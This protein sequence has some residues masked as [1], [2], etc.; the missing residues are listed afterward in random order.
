MRALRR[1]VVGLGVVVV[2]LALV[3]VFGGG[4]YY[5]GELL[6][7]PTYVPD[8]PDRDATFEGDQVTLAAD[9]ETCLE[10]VGLR[11]AE[12]YVQ[13][14][15]PLAACPEGETVTRPY[16]SVIG[17]PSE[18]PTQVAADLYFWPG[19]PATAGLRFEEVAVPGPFGDLP[20]W[21]LA[22]DDPTWVVAV[23]GRGASRGEALRLASILVD[24]GHPMLIPS[25]RGDGTAPAPDGGIGRFGTEEWEDVEAAVAW[26]REQG[27]GAVVLA[28]FSQGGSAVAFFLERSAH[29]AGI[30]GA[31]LDAPLL[32]LPATLEL[33]AQARD[34]PAVLIP[35]ILFG[36]G[37]V[38]RLRAGLV[39]GEVD[40]VTAAEE[41]RVP[42]LLFHGD[43]DDSVPIGPSD[44][45]AAA[46]PDSVTYVRVEDAGH[47]QSWNRDPAAYAEAVSTFLD[48][49][50]PGV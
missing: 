11:S 44:T 40:H 24:L 29:A 13:L 39:I 17:T 5:S 46:L 35:P 37:I 20:S 48:R 23:H 15:E 1:V 2:L 42:I 9:V 19:D 34:L 18:G 41:L 47:V 8:P 7:A 36:T 33:Q 26:A 4:W 6:P 3:V 43:A 30:A 12:A 31:I 14:D 28:G 27:A 25:I 21:Y 32:D 38:T 49:V 10:R 16:R 22:G 45:L 50:A